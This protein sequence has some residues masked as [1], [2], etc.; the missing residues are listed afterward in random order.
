MEKIDIVLWVMSGGFS[1]MLIMWGTLNTRIE[2]CEEK[3]NSRMDAIEKKIDKLDEKVTDIDRR[4]CR[5]EGAMSNQE[6]CAIRSSNDMRK[7]E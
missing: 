3:L 7:A 2:K 5:I 1:L 6:G 4:V